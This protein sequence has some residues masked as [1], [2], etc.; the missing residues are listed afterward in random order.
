MY[1]DKLPIAVLRSIDLGDT[2]DI[3]NDI[4]L[5]EN[6][7]LDISWISSDD[8]I[9]SNYGKVNIP[10][11]LSA[12]MEVFLEAKIQHNDQEYSRRFSF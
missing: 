3:T 7:K 10:D 1:N 11:T 6:N 12:D 8:R 2:S 5:P 4:H 9:I